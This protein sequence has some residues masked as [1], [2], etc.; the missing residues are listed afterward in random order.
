MKRS[1]PV[2]LFRIT[3]NFL[4]ELRKSTIDLMIVCVPAKVEAV[5]L[6]HSSAALS[7]ERTSSVIT[8]E[9]TPILTFHFLLYSFTLYKMLAI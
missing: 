7:S 3:W 2:S 8:A 9:S 4:Q 6:P 5:H 1:L